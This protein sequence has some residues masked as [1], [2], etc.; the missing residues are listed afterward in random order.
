MILYCHRALKHTY[1]RVT[2]WKFTSKKEM[3]ACFSKGGRLLPLLMKHLLHLM[4]YNFLHKH[5]F[6]L[7]F[8]AYK[9]LWKQFCLLYV[10]KHIFCSKWLAD[11]TSFLY[12]NCQKEIYY[13]ASVHWIFGFCFKLMNHAAGYILFLPLSSSL[14][15]KKII[16]V[17]HYIVK[18]AA[19][20]IGI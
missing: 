6:S 14:K 3:G 18:A 8:L 12:K 1:F 13:F 9:T 7:V 11:F 19:K 5:F 15:M 2:I 16:M 4:T 20:T 17:L 10:H